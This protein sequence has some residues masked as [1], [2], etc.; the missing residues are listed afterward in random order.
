M[1]EKDWPEYIDLCI[2]Y[3]IV[4]LLF[5]T[6][7]YVAM[8]IYYKDKAGYQF[9]VMGMAVSCFLSSWLYKKIGNRE[10]WL[11]IMF[12]LE[13]FAYGIF[14]MVSGGF[15]SPYL[16][17]QMNCILLMI[18]LEKYIGVTIMASAW[19]FF[20]VV[21]GKIESGLTYQELN[22]ALGIIIV[23]GGFYVLR[24]YI[25]RI[26][27][28]KTELLAL[29]EKLEEEKEKSEAAFLKLTGVYE[30]F[31]LFAMTN[32][33]KIIKEL[34]QLLKRAIAPEGCMLVKLD[35]S[36]H[37]QKIEHLG[38]E[39]EVVEELLKEIAKDKLESVKKRGNYEFDLYARG[40]RYRTRFIGE[41]TSLKGLFIRHSED[42]EQEKE[43][44]YWKLIDII[45]TNLDIHTQLERFI[46]ME[47]Q[48]RIANEIHDTVIQK[49]FGVVCSLK[50]MESKAS[51]KEDDE[52]KEHIIMLKRSIELT[53]TELRESIYGRRFKD[54]FHTFIGTM[55]LYMEEAERLSNTKICMDIDANSDYMSPAQKIAVY[56]ISCEAVNNAIRHGN[57]SLV[58]INLKLFPEQIVLKVED[59]GDGFIKKQEG[60]YEGNGLKNMKNIAE[61]LKGRLVL[62]TQS[63]TGMKVELV[64]PR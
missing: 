29:N 22:V 17:Y 57:A 1:A 50:V 13:V 46:T 10:P 62:D 48:N 38:L 6:I 23:I 33:E 63:K 14:T 34:L 21:A 36:F 54:T 40:E 51:S 12:A 37:P 49:L 56:R 26:N 8:S 27:E 20:T 2:A 7:V 39:D 44:F 61:L 9:V 64:L 59:N 31:N 35:S 52:F 30:T 60:L 28:Q 15:S 53:M 42:I 58:N 25:G 41:D 16:W 47:E 55:K 32:P 24:F 45:F 5:S 19:C 18:T 11:R 43:E 4:T 3:R